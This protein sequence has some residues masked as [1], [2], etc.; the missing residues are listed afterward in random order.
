MGVEVTHN[1]GRDEFVEV[2]VEEVLEVVSG[3]GV[4]V[5]DIYNSE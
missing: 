5:V 2:V 3:L 1:Q 4:F